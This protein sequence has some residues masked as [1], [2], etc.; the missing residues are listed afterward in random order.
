M[1]KRG[2]TQ[3]TAD[4]IRAL[5][6]RTDLVTAGSVLGIGRTKA[7]EMARHKTFP[8]QVLRLGHRYVV[9]VAGLLDVLGLGEQSDVSGRVAEPNLATAKG[10]GAA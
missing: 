5:G 3:W 6:V 2:T 4:R 9:P 7:H 10:N 1:G 8:V